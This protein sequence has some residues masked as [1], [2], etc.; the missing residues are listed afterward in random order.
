MSK[1]EGVL[2]R[3][4]SG[5]QIDSSRRL[6]NGS[7]LDREQ[8][9]SKLGSIL[10]RAIVAASLKPINAEPETP[11]QISDAPLSADDV[12]RMHDGRA[13]CAS[14]AV[15]LGV[16]RSTARNRLNELIKDGRVKTKG[17]GPATVYILREVHP[18]EERRSA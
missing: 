6:T 3:I 8:S 16:S 7:V 2:Q 5:K 17:R 15:Q 12:L 14:V 18:K 11:K 10:A 9:I 13:S 1:R 4:H